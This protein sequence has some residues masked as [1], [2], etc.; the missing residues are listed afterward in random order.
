MTTKTTFHLSMSR[1]SLLVAHVRAVLAQCDPLLLLGLPIGATLVSLALGF[2][3]Y[4][5]ISTPA[6][7][8]QTTTRPIILIATARPVTT[9]PTRAAAALPTAAPRLVTAYT[10]PNGAAFPDR[11][12][13]PQPSSWIARWGDEWISIQWTPNPVW[14]RA[15]DVG[16]QLADVQP[17]PSV[18]LVPVA[19]PL[20]P[21]PAPYQ[22]SNE[23]LPAAQ[24]DATTDSDLAAHQAQQAA[25]CANGGANTQPD[26]C[27]L[28]QQ[29]MEA[30]Q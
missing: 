29:W 17:V 25:W 7:A 28:V 16:A 9:P 27:A 14:I 4:R 3:L 10:S 18:E 11:I 6:E 15:A 8:A 1:R 22:V 23:P 30:H 21:A 5:A 20:A 2:S 19:V 12:P 13:E 24:P 26:Y